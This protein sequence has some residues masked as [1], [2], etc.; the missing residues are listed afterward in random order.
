MASVP[1]A[2]ALP[3]LALAANPLLDDFDAVMAEH[4]RR[5]FRVLL[6]I[7]HDEDAAQTLTQEC[8]LKAWRARTTFRGESPVGAWLLRI[9]VNLGRDHVRS[10]RAGFWRRLFAADAEPQ[11]VE[12]AM[13]D[14]R[15]S[16]ERDLLAREQVEAV[17]AAAEKLS[18]Q[19][20]TVFILRFAE[21]MSL[22]EIA[23]AT[24]L[25]T[26]T[27]K[28]HLFRALASVRASVRK[29]NKESR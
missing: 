16:A 2:E 26:G 9:A 21:E 15:P 24:G 22:D 8:F 25:R 27:V 28:V 6:A 18:P 5:I 11:Q 17:W 4:Q 7:T 12:A 3:A 14:E 10:R 20:R 19:Q 23:K 29:Q 13:A 1:N